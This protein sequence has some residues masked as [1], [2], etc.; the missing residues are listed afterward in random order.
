MI[1]RL[2]TA[3]GR[4]IPNGQDSELSAYEQ[5]WAADIP[6]KYPVKVLSH[7]TPTYNCHGLTFASRRTKITDSPAI[8]WILD[9]DHYEPV[10]R[11]AARPGDVIVYRRDGEP[12]HSGIVL[13]N[14][15]DLF[16]PIIWSKWGNGPEVRHNYLDVPSVYGSDHQFYRC[17]L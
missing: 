4:D 6:A 14:E 10:A 11:Q 1:I 9:D 8:S 2:Q 17:K 15:P 13:E 16:V 3:A 7:L 5:N 12:T